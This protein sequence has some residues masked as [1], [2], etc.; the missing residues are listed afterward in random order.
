MFIDQQLSATMQKC[1]TEGTQAPCMSVINRLIHNFKTLNW[2]KV[3]WDTFFL[4]DDSKTLLIQKG[5]YSQL[6]VT[7]LLTDDFYTHQRV[8]LQHT[9]GS[10]QT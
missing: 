5:N 10:I 3:V 7:M 2:K 4:K 9:P 6:L 1:W 8:N